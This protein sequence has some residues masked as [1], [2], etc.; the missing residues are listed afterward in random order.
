VAISIAVKTGLR[1]TAG[2]MPNPTVIESVQASAVAA[3][4]IPLP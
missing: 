3:E 1:T 2:I 4:A